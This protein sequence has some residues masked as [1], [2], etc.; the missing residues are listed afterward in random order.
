MKLFKVTEP[1]LE[2]L[3]GYKKSLCSQSSKVV[4]YESVI[5]VALTL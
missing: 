4:I 2:A 1:Q 3:L 5:T